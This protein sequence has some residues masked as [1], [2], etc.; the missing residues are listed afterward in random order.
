MMSN[1]HTPD[2]FLGYAGLCGLGWAGESVGGMN[3]STFSFAT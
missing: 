2:V 1:E 3:A